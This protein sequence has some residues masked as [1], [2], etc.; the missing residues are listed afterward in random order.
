MSEK[1]TLDELL[2]DPMVKLVMA[3][4]SVNPEELRVALTMRTRP[5]AVAVALSVPAA[6]PAAHVIDQ[7]C[8]MRRN[9]AMDCSC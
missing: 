3:R 5:Q 8:R 7:V 4:D 1:M 9:N 2:D 6:L